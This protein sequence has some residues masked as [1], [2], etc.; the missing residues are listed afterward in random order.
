MAALDGVT[1][2]THRQLHGKI[3]RHDDPAWEAIYPPNGFNCR[4]RVIAMTEGRA[5]AEMAGAPEAGLTGDAPETRDVDLVSRQTGEVFRRPVT[6]VRLTDGAGHVRHFQPDAGWGYNPG[7]HVLPPAN[8]SSPPPARL[9]A[10]QNN[11]ADFKFAE[12]VIAPARRADAPK[13]LPGYATDDQLIAASHKIVGINVGGTRRITAPPGVDDVVINSNGLSHIARR[14]DKFRARYVARLIPTIESPDEVWLAAYK[15]GAKNEN[16][17]HFIKSWSDDKATFSVTTEDHRGNVFITFFPVGKLKEL[18][19]RRVGQPLYVAPKENED[20][21]S[22]AIKFIDELGGARYAWG[23]Y[24]PALHHFL[25]ESIRLFGQ[26]DFKWASNA[27]NAVRLMLDKGMEIS[28]TRKTYIRYG[29]TPDSGTSH[30]YRDDIAEAGVS[31][32]RP[33]GSGEKVDEI[34]KLFISAGRDAKKIEG[35][36]I[37]DAAGSDNEALIVEAVR[38]RKA[39]AKK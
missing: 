9:I 24:D 25:D 34:S 8:S 13:I 11:W 1:R 33:A 14:E 37:L 7:R 23:S 29:D 31:V 3:L 20:V 5:R 35:Y 17:V 6:R 16:R 27:A 4:C 18:Q 32:Y 28:R 19:K 12:N 39:G 36:E 15:V 26:I 21:L 30:N 38:P 10:G 2:L 22:A